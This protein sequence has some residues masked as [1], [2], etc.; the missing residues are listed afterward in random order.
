[1]F[2]IGALLSIQPY[3][4]GADSEDSGKIYEL[5]EQSANTTN[6]ASNSY[7]KILGNYRTDLSRKIKRCWFPPKDGRGGVLRFTLNRSGEV[8]NLSL[9]F[10]SGITASDEA[11]LNAVRLAMP[12]KAVPPELPAPLEVE[13]ELR[14]YT[15]QPPKGKPDG[16]ILRSRR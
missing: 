1:M 13:L 3:C 16:M 14:S 2:A 7:N 9:R 8:S 5:V 11:V 10:S 12:F 6:V 15:S 4:F